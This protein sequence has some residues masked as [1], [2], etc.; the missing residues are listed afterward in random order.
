MNASPTAPL[1][2]FAVFSY[3]QERFIREAVESALSQTRS[4][5]Q[6]ILSDDGSKDRTF[7]IMKQMA[8]DYRGPHE[9][10]LNRN[11]PNLGIGAHVS[12]VISMAKSELIVGLAGDDACDSSR[13]EK[14]LG[15]WEA[16]RRP[17]CV[18]YSNAVETDIEGG[19][20]GET[21][22]P[23]GRM[24]TIIDV[25]NG[26][27]PPVIGCSQAWHRSLFD[28]FGP[29]PPEVMNEDGALWFRASILGKVLHVP[30]KL[31][32]HRNHG[33]NT[34]SAGFRPGMDA[35]EWLA[36]TANSWRRFSSVLRCNLADLAV[37]QAAGRACEN[38]EEI[39]RLLHRGL[40]N[41]HHA[42][43]V[44]S[45]TGLKKWKAAG[46]LMLQAPAAHHRWHLLK[47]LWPRFFLKLSSIRA[48]IKGRQAGQ[49]AAA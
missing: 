43:T 8:A 26:A 1:V 32:R 20:I 38:Q 47:M 11:D 42:E 21:V 35:R 37:L 41:A 27:C 33:S 48:G 16:A 39:A 4:P 7:E 44:C 2:T 23:S 25:L 18:I 14:Y 40:R 49:P 28:F 46:S 30:E 45:S 22:M 9:I 10:L 6:I 36:T 5:L 12:K 17:V 15:C 29:L 19:A 13:T 3:N 31:V 34:G 24:A